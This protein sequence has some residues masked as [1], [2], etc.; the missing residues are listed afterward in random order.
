[1]KKLFFVFAIVLAYGLSVSTAN[2]I[3]EDIEKTKVTVVEDS[4][5]N[6]TSDT[7]K[8]EGTKAKAAKAEGCSSA[9]AKAESCADGKAKAE[10]CS[11]AAA[12]AEGCSGTAAKADGCANKAKTASATKTN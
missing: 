7:V 9:E 2:V 10:G 8:E 3:S 6:K 1:M 5:D 4:G 12:K 11:K